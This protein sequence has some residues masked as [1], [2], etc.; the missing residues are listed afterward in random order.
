MINLSKIN[1]PIKESIRLRLCGYCIK[2]KNRSRK[3]KTEYQL[4]YHITHE[5]KDDIG[6]IE[7]VKVNSHQTL[8]REILDFD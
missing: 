2:I 6:I 3:F 5:H 8:E 7:P 4:T 1:L